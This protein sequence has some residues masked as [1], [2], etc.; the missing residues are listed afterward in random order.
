MEGSIKSAYYQNSE[1]CYSSHSQDSWA[2]ETGPETWLLLSPSDPLVKCLLPIPE[3]L[4]S[5]SLDWPVR[6]ASTR[7]KSNASI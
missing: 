4:D 7:G 2:W 6:T 5:A 1:Q 3:T